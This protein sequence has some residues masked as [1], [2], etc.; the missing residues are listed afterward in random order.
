MRHIDTLLARRRDLAEKYVSLLSGLSGGL[1]EG[2]VL[3]RATTHGEHSYQSFCVHTENRDNVIKQMAEA[4]I[5]A[6]IGT[7]S[8]HMHRAFAENPRCRITADMTG[9][10]RAFQ[11]CL[12]LP[13]Y[14][15]LTEDAQVRVIE[16]LKHIQGLT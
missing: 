4:G 7:Y 11:Q 8:L 1:P 10:V 9:S 16:T 13:L 6:Q 3:P 14:H 12:T 5:E 2:I 15:D